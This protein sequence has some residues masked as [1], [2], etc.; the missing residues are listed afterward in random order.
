MTLLRKK[1]RLIS[2]L[3][4]KKSESWVVEDQDK[5]DNMDGAGQIGVFIPG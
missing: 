3:Q 1:K 5:K 4:R 2:P